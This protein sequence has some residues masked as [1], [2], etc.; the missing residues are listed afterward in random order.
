M[1]VR[2]VVAGL[3]QTSPLLGVHRLNGVVG[4]DGLVVAGAVPAGLEGRDLVPDM[5][6]HASYAV[7]VPAPYLLPPPTATTAAPPAPRRA[8]TS[9]GG[10]GGKEGRGARGGDGGQWRERNRE[11]AMCSSRSGHTVEGGS[12]PVRPLDIPKRPARCR[13]DDTRVWAWH[14][15]P[16]QAADLYMGR[17]VGLT[18]SAPPP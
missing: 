5:F 4:E 3:L 1:F 8:V 17:F 13:W 10:L 18:W 6:T 14:A 16:R 11:E 7:R 15:P 12:G 9:G 2:L